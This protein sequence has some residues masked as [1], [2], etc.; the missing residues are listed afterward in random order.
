MGVYTH[1][2]NAREMIM[3]VDYGMK[4]LEVLKSATSV[5]ADQF[6]YKDRGRIVKG[7]LADLVAVEGDP[8]RQIEIIRK[9]AFVMKDGI[10]YKDVF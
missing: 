3:M 10:I 8:T 2:D 7:L 1:G 4:P 5:N 9:V 6:G